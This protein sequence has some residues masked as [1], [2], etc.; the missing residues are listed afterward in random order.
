MPGRK[1]DLIA[2]V[3]AALHRAKY[4]TKLQHT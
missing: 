2:G 3:I 1:R 4:Y